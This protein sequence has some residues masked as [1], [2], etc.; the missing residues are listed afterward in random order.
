MSESSNKTISERVEEMAKLAGTIA[1][2]GVAFAALV[3][4]FKKK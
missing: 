3:S 2:A 1:T 4:S